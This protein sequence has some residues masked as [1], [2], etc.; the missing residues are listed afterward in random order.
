MVLDASPRLVGL[1]P[2]TSPHTPPSV[3]ELCQPHPLVVTQP[4]HPATA[5][6]SDAALRELLAAS[7]AATCTQITTQRI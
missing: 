3:S 4:L 7:A 6:H 2:S 5:V 1:S